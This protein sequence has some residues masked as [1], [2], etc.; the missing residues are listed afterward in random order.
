MGP[1]SKR[2]VGTVRVYVQ[3]QVRGQ[4]PGVNTRVLPDGPMTNCQIAVTD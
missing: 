3:E 2:L 1:M 4:L